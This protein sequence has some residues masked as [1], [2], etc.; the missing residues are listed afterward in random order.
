M[1]DGGDT[2]LPP[3]QGFRR[4]SQIHVVAPYFAAVSSG[5]LT[6]FVPH[7]SG[8]QDPLVNAFTF[9]SNYDLL[10]FGSGRG[11]PCDVNPSSGTST[12]C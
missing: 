10:L 4:Q 3:R 9:T 1:V 12:P 5:C 7:N 11:V 8:K 6:P 2:E